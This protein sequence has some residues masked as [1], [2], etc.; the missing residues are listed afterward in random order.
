MSLANK[1][2]TTCFVF[3]FMVSIAQAVDN[4]MVIWNVILFNLVDRY[5]PCFQALPF[6]AKHTVDL[7]MS[8]NRDRDCGA[9]MD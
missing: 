7:V 1:S 2:H 3:G 5:C 9:H 4:V 6:S 8:A